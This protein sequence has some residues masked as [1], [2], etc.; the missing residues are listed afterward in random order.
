[1]VWEEITFLFTFFQQSLFDENV[2]WM[3]KIVNR[4]K[5]KQKQSTPDQGDDDAYDDCND[6]DDDVWVHSGGSW[7]HAIIS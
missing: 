7:K 3:E 5:R 4:G 6:D 1:M 2:I